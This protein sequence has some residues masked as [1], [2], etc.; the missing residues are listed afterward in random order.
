M[1]QPTITHFVKNL[2]KGQPSNLKQETAD[3]AHS[4]ASDHATVTCDLSR[5]KN[6]S[7]LQVSCEK[8]LAGGSKNPF[9]VKKVVER[10][11]P[12][13]DS[14]SNEEGLPLNQVK[15][16]QRGGHKLL[17][18]K[19]RK[20]KHRTLSI[21][22]QSAESCSKKV[23][24]GTVNEN[25]HP[26]STDCRNPTG[27][28]LRHSEKVKDSEK[29]KISDARVLSYEFGVEEATLMSGYALDS[30]QLSTKK[31]SLADLD[32]NAKHSSSS[33]CSPIKNQTPSKDRILSKMNGLALSS[34][35]CSPSFSPR[36]PIP[37]AFSPFFERTRPASTDGKEGCLVNNHVQASE[38]VEDLESSAVLFS[39]PATTENSQEALSSHSTSK[40]VPRR[41]LNFNDREPDKPVPLHPA[42]PVYQVNETILPSTDGHLHPS[43]SALPP[44]PSVAEILHRSSAS[45]DDFSFISDISLSEFADA[46]RIEMGPD[47]STVKTSRKFA[48]NRHLVLE[49]TS[50]ECGSEDAILCTGR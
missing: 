18:L 20:R 44:P 42:S 32:I 41:M 43:T 30:E 19:D 40:S 37:K 8:K 11:S 50:Q 7:H 3:V 39:T 38:S 13:S 47:T 23:C 46:S 45:N 6:P 21:S 16:Q 2:S 27:H 15:P 5:D 24:S 35:P 17:S 12:S 14:T 9:A 29:I 33:V 10:Q 36:K 49:V 31:L 22:P 26:N 34:I 25:A 28:V 48:L 4:D 1:V